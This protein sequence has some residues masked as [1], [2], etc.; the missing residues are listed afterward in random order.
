MKQLLAGVTLLFVI[1]ICSFLYRNTVERPGVIMP[2]VACTLEAKIC[3][4]GTS[5]GREGLGCAFASCAFPNAEIA[6]AGVSFVIP[7]GYVADRSVADGEASVLAS[8]AKPSTLDWPPHVI[9]VHRY[10]I[11]EGGTGD[12]VIFANTRYQPADEAATDFSRFK[13]LSIGGKTFRETTIERFEGLVRTS[14]FL[15]RENDVLRFDVIEKGVQGWTDPSFDPRTLPEHQ[16]LR[17]LLSTLQV[18]P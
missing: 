17:A 5:V 3:P 10:P 15:A 1:G 6:S 7:D 16:A 12:D 11:P 8:Y 2:D 9:I 4:D 13:D 18:S 14:Y